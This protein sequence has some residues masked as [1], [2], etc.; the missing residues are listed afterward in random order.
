MQTV[1]KQ[2]FNKHKAYFI[3]IQIRI[4]QNTDQGFTGS[5]DPDPD[6]SAIQYP[7]P[8]K[9]VRIGHTGKLANMR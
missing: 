8:E 5:G 1:L 3:T 6:E 9:M 7:D 4:F 2:F